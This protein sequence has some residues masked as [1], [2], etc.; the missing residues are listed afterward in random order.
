MSYIRAF[1]NHGSW[2]K[3]FSSPA[4]DLSS[5]FALPVDR[6][7][8]I[9]TLS[10]EA[11]LLSGE[12]VWITPSDK[13]R[14][15]DSLFFRGSRRHDIGQSHDSPQGRIWSSYYAIKDIVCVQDLQVQM[16][17]MDEDEWLTI[18]PDVLKRLLSSEQNKHSDS[19]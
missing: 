15:V 16:Y 10:C 18:E 2:H 14:L 8:R 3:F 12:I 1:E 4:G 6:V 17:Y 13:K 9:D 19:E 11:E 7:A 5:T